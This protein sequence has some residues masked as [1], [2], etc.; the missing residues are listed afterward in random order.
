M[1]QASSGMGAPVASTLLGMV[2]GGSMASSLAAQAQ[3]SAQRSAMQK[4]A[5]RMTAAYQRMA[6]AQEQL[7]YAQARNDHL[8]GMFLDRKCKL[9]EA[10]AAPGG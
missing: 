8:V 6:Q 5:S 1:Q 4:G 7:A 9:P 2:P 3:A 10:G